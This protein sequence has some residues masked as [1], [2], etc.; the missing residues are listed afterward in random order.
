M[1]L[2][3]TRCPRIRSRRSLGSPMNARPLDA[4]WAMRA[5]SW[6][7]WAWVAGFIVCVMTGVLTARTSGSP[8]FL[9]LVKSQADSSNQFP[10][11]GAFI[12]WRNPN[13]AKERE[14]LL[15]ICSGVLIHE[16]AFLTAGHCVGPGVRGIPP[17]TEVS[18]SFD[19]KDA[20]DRRTWLP[21][22]RLII[23]PS[24]PESCQSPPGCNPTRTDAF[25]ALDPARADL[26]LAILARP[27]LGIRPV[28][29]AR[30]E[31][32][33]KP[34]ARTR[35]MTIVGYGSTAPIPS[36][37]PP[38]SSLFWDG[39][40]RFRSSSLD[41]VVNDYWAT[42]ALPSRVC[43]GDSGAPTFV[44]DPRVR[45][46]ARRLVAI[47]SDGGVDCA[48]IDARVR[49]DTAAVQGWIARVIRQ[50]VSARR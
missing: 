49:I 31:T 18:V 6:I 22:A 20:F 26:G 4:A 48:S 46:S 19:R 43:S 7:R 11:V 5:S 30:P 21:V 10:E 14:G 34:A 24:L 40:R 41:K 1:A 8:V 37:R 44:E 23:H 13:P 45:K 12:A 38:A 3:R 28:A 33:T 50:E 47:A 32:L 16:R 29:L 15:G 2:Q 36:E 17:Y 35:P 25:R 27:V 9:A 42:W 39:I